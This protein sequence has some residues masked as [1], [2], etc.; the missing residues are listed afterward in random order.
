MAL[1]VTIL[2]TIFLINRLHKEYVKTLE[3]DDKTT[4]LLKDN[5]RITFICTGLILMTGSLTGFIVYHAFTFFYITAL[6]LTIFVYGYYHEN[7]KINLSVKYIE[8]MAVTML[9]QWIVLSIFFHQMLNEISTYDW[10]FL[11]T[12]SMIIGCYFIVQF[13]MSDITLSDLILD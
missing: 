1:S 3:S 6:G 8:V 11:F 10:T 2:T 7:G 9:L 4:I 12:L 5:K 13:I